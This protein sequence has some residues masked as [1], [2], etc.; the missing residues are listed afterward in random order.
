MHTKLYEF[1]ARSANACCVGCISLVASYCV[2]FITH[3]PRIQTAHR[4]DIGEEGNEKPSHQCS[5]RYKNSGALR[6]VSAK[7]QIDN[8]IQLISRCQFPLKKARARSL[9]FYSRNQINNAV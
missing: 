9:V 6:L 1:E 3:E 2:S 4:K 8:A 5:L 7:P